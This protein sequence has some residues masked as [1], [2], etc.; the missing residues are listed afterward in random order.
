MK[1][2]CRGYV[3]IMGSSEKFVGAAVRNPCE[4]LKAHPRRPTVMRF[5]HRTRMISS[6][7]SGVRVVK[8]LFVLSTT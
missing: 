8:C 6:V 7:C 2:L 3:V 1:E 5:W 4:R